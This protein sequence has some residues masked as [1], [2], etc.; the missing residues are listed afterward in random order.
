M[1]GKE[2]ACCYSDVAVDCVAFKYRSIR[3][4]LLPPVAAAVSVFLSQAGNTYVIF[5]R[6]CLF[7]CTVFN[8][9]RSWRYNAVGARLSGAPCNAMN[10]C[11]SHRVGLV[12]QTRP[13]PGGVGFRRQII[14]PL[15]RSQ[16]SSGREQTIY[17]RSHTT[18][19]TTTTANTATA[20]SLF[21][22]SQVMRQIIVPLSRSQSSSGREQTIYAHTTTNTATT[23]T[24]TATLLGRSHVSCLCVRSAAIWVM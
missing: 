11:A 18:T 8:L 4:L 21:G 20:T 15:S 19:T 13:P 16:S 17:K 3:S 14:V 12:Q 2:S 24:A 10:R 7:V 22:R 1:S 9:H 6:F 5:P 23:N